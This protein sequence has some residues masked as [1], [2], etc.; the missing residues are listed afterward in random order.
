MENL[1]QKF[2]KDDSGIYFHSSPPSQDLYDSIWKDTHNLDSSRI[3]KP[4]NIEAT[5]EKLSALILPT[6]YLQSQIVKFSSDLRVLEVCA[7]H[8]NFSLAAVS[9]GSRNVYMCDGSRS[10]LLHMSELLKEPEFFEHKKSLNLLQ[11]DIEKISTSLPRASFDLVFQ[12]FAIHHMRNPAKT[13]YDLAN[14]VK[15]GGLLCFNYFTTGCTHQI[16][17]DLR[18]FFL[19]KDFEY[20]KRLFLDF[21]L[22]K[23]INREAHLRSALYDNP[24]FKSEFPEA[25][26]FLMSMAEKYGFDL[27][28]KKLHYEDANTPYL[29]NIDRIYM[30]KFVT[31]LG[32]RVVDKRDTVDEQT[33]TLAVPSEGIKA[34]EESQIPSTLE[35][36]DEDISLGDNLI[37]RCGA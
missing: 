7:G 29:H 36:S 24:S 30:E 1:L 15:P 31:S 5:A 9:L 3:K 13:A 16:N 17:R 33:L 26:E 23:N 2:T 14:L 18:S 6:A 35:F 37:S 22:C 21:N 19:K 25:H 20:I 32:L 28:A 34:L 27:L 10:A 12:R 11:I 8:G 4:E